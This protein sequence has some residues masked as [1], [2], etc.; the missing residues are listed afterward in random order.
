MFLKQKISL[1]MQKFSSF[2]TGV[3]DL[4]LTVKLS[5]KDEKYHFPLILFMKCSHLCISHVHHHT[6]TG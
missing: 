4:K 2:S 5:E 1:K 3:M 6:L